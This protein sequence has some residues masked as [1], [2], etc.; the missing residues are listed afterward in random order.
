MIHE[1]TLT[2]I[3]WGRE[4]YVAMVHTLYN[5]SEDFPEELQSY[6][7][8]L[9]ALRKELGNDT[10]PSVDML[11]TAVELQCCS[12]MLFAGLQG[13]KMNYDH[14]RNPMLP[15]VTWAQI[16]FEN[17]WQEPVAD[18]LPM[19]LQAQRVI[20]SFY[21]LLTPEQKQRLFQPIRSY[22]NTL[23]CEAPKLAHYYGYLFGN[24]LLPLVVPAYCND[25]MLE[26][27]YDSYL[28]DYF[29]Q[30]VDRSQ[31]KGVF[32]P[33]QWHLA[34]VKEKEHDEAQRIRKTVLQ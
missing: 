26:M 30:P 8:A 29:G 16:D 11:E 15:N 24:S 21:D 5:Q 22:I 6:H 25:P 31:W 14:F 10:R 7:R 34:P 19:Y 17:A 32:Q 1:S 27:R 3:L 20:D 18:T 9:E 13:L 12:D 2:R 28:K 23:R 33:R 4:T